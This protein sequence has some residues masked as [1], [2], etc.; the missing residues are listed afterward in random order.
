MQTKRKLN[1][2]SGFANFQICHP[3]CK[4][5]HRC[6]IGNHRF[7]NRFAHSVEAVSLHACKRYIVVTLHCSYAKDFAVSFLF[8]HFPMKL[9][10][11]VENTMAI[12]FGGN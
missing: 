6:L 11:N 4:G 10:E 3:I 7:C 9:T 5:L 8:Y 2:F 1:V 12:L